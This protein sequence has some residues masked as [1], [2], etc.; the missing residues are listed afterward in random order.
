MTDHRQPLHIGEIV[1]AKVQALDH[2]GAWIDIDGRRAFVPLGEIAW[3]EVEHPSVLLSVGTHIQ[4]RVTGVTDQGVVECSIRR[5]ERNGPAEPDVLVTA[6]VET[7]KHSQNVYRYNWRYNAFTLYRA[8]PFPSRCPFEIGYIPATADMDGE[9]LRVV[10]LQSTSTF[11]GCEIGCRVVGLLKTA[12]DAE[13]GEKLL[14]VSTVDSNYDDV[15]DLTDVPHHTLRKI[16]HY[17]AADRSA[18]HHAFTMK[19]WERADAGRL[20]VKE[21]MAHYQDSGIP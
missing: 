1:Q 3:Y 5:L 18:D 11:P 10:I 19:G 9:P 14:G 4:V 8:L 21:A 16:A 15:Y 12:D 6:V 13:P 17:F 20:L 7:P 2:S